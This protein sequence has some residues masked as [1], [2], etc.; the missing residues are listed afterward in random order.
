MDG[1]SWLVKGHQPTAPDGWARGASTPSGQLRSTDTESGLW[2]RRIFARQCVLE[3]KAGPETEMD[4][5]LKS[6]G[7]LHR[8][9]IEGSAFERGQMHGHLL[10]DPIRSHL[11]AWAHAVQRN[12]GI[13]STRLINMVLA[14]T[15]FIPA[16]KR[17]TP[18]LLLEIQGIA[19][20][21]GV[22]PDAI[23]TL[24]LLDEVWSRYGKAGIPQEHCSSIGCQGT[25]TSPPIIAQNMDIEAFRDGFQTVVHMSDPILKQE[26]L[27]LSFA[28]G[29]GLNGLNDRGLGVCVNSLLQL[30]S[31][32]DGLPVACVVRGVLEK[33]D[34]SKAREFLLQVKHATGQNYLVGAKD[35]IYDVECSANKADIFQLDHR[36][37]AVWHTNHP[38]QNDDISERF[39]NPSATFRDSV[40]MRYANSSTRMRSLTD[41]L[42]SVACIDTGHI[43]AALEAKDSEQFPV[44]VSKGD[45][46]KS[47]TFASS[48]MVLGEE[49]ELLIAPG[50]PDVTITE[51]ISFRASKATPES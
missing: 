43:M 37:D 51:R 42:G 40:D 38:L 39:R 31:S 12:Y 34:A 30:N 32:L 33:A 46:L 6:A 18:D 29:I 9:R 35:G 8:I 7:S 24:N 16:I 14:E 11:S 15:N 44:C 41:R 22:D 10:R 20:G 4:E 23:Y 3:Y 19:D 27:F 26:T 28:G 5:S 13:D 25:A 1:L 36:A 49:P 47:F 45:L 21:A 50:P 48:V 2:S 17:W